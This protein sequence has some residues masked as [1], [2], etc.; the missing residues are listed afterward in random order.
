MM[1]KLKL[2]GIDCAACSSQI[3]SILKKIDGIESVK[4]NFLSS[5]VE[6]ESSSFP[7]LKTIEKKLSFFGYSL[8]KERVS[9]KTD[10][11][12]FEMVKDDII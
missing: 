3:S 5:N 6:M 9:I 7:D 12:A 1:V 8:P 10:V 11:E 2:Y 4:V